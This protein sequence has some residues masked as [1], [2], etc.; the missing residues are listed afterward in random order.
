VTRHRGV[1][2]SAAEVSG[3]GALNRTDGCGRCAHLR[4]VFA[5]GTDVF[6]EDGDHNTASEVSHLNM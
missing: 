6:I 4:D 2:A 5:W 1:E 3:E